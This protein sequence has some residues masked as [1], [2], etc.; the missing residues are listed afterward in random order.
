MLGT[1]VL[2]DGKI[3]FLY[4]DSSA[5]Q[6]AVA[7][8]FSDWRPLGMAP[9][10]D[11]WWVIEL[12]P[13]PEGDYFYKFVTHS[14]WHPD[15][16]NYRRDQNGDSSFINVGGH[17]GHLLRRGFFSQ[18][19]GKGKSYVIYLPPHY[20]VDGW[21]SFPVLY[22]MG[23]LFEGDT[24]WV[25]R[26]H[27]EEKLDHLAGTGDA[28]EMIVVMPD[29]DDAVFHENAWGSY[30]AYLAT[31]LPQHIEGEYRTL[32]VRAF[33]GLSMGGSW[34]LRLG[35]TLPERY[36]SVSSLS[37]NFSPDFYELA[38]ANRDRAMAAGVRVRIACGDGEQG[39][40]PNN[41]QY[42]GFLQELGISSEF[43]VNSGP[44]DWP[45]WRAQ[46]DNSIR[47]HSYSFRQRM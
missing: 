5:H 14:G 25:D 30:F 18:A 17:C 33:E 11:G 24:G 31:D 26:C 47:F 37:G 7:G 28:E 8:S 1:H 44:H 16:F 32:P 3:R 23:G 39:V 42:N 15:Q 40:I 29:K 10:G 36:C 45:L 4:H 21:R 35:L 41:A 20:A 9:S 6:V 13:M 22:L 19:L 27:I 12:G 38:R 2:Q 34:A 43:H 46:I